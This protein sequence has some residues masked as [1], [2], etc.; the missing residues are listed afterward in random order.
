MKNS[1][2]FRLFCSLG[3]NCEFGIAQQLAEADAHD[4]LRFGHTPLTS[5]IDLLREEFRDLADRSLLRV[6]LPPTGNASSVE[7]IRH[8]VHWHAWH[9]ECRTAPQKL[10]DREAR[11]VPRLA[12]KLLE[13]LREE[14]RIFVRLCLPG[15]SYA[16]APK[17]VEALGRYGRPRLLFV[18]P[19]EHG[20]V[21]WHFDREYGVVRG[22]IPLRS[23]PSTDTVSVDS[24]MV[25]CK[26]A[27]DLLMLQG[28]AGSKASASPSEFV[29]GRMES[30]Q[31]TSDGSSGVAGWTKEGSMT[32]EI[33]L[34]EEAVARRPTDAALRAKLGNALSA[35]G[36]PDQAAESMRHAIEL[37]PDNAAYH[38]ALAHVLAGQGH[39]ADAFSEV[40]E[41]V[42]LAPANVAYIAHL[43]NLSSGIGESAAAL[44]LMSKAIELAPASAQ[45]HIGLS[46]LFAKEG[47]IDEAILAAQAAIKL[48]PDDPR[49]H[50]HKANLLARQDKFEESV[51]ALEVAASIAP[52]EQYIRDAMAHVR[53]LEQRAALKDG[54]QVE[55]NPNGCAVESDACL[56]TRGFVAA[57]DDGPLTASSVP[58]YVSVEPQANPPYGREDD[59]DF[60]RS[61]PLVSPNISESYPPE[62]TPSR[63]L[64]RLKRR[65]SL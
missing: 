14:R 8:R 49:T 58:Q 28:A 61:S 40:Q 42:K 9:E 30:L 37:E 57:R 31:S 39:T 44:S 20:E 59:T 54:A 7:N 29:L 47:R 41:A 51:E 56:A 33:S 6:L 38:M 48:N 63:L 17:L 15:E 65:F 11:R 43:A 64:R 32:D 27:V 62:R 34:L 4:L 18:E 10:L 26:A 13:D 46:H 52:Q 60:R 1:D 2:F 16:D 5:L 53:T 23:V 25:L 12:S 21:T 35:R 50:Y 19:S 45:L 3:G 24:W 36:K 22:R 55:R